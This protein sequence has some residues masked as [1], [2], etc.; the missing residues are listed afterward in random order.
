MLITNT[1]LGSFGFELEE[2]RTGKLRFDE[3]SMLEL[4]L[5]RTQSLLQGTVNAD[6]ELLADAATEL[7]QRALDKVRA[8]VSTLADNDAVCAIQFRNQ[9]F[10][11]SDMGQVRMSLQR[12]SQDNL[13]EEEQSLEGSFEGVLPNKR[14][15]F[16]FKLK[17]QG[18]VIVGKI[19]HA[20]TNLD[21]INNHLHQETLI[22]VMM[23]RVGEGRPRYLL[24]EMPQWGGEGS[25]SYSIP[26][27]PSAPMLTSR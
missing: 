25:Q 2:Y 12:L 4:A 27:T 20:L 23:T 8:F 5:E 10:R 1:A 9:D 13:R 18:E 15:A 11:F 26:G 24:V 6:D 21:E 7:D 17:W 3:Q 19:S 22:K 16:E 14:R